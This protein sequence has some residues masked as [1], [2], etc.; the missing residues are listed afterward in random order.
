MALQVLR[1]LSVFPWRPRSGGHRL[2]GGRRGI[3]ILT[4]VFGRRI[5]APH[6]NPK[7]EELWSLS[8][9]QP[10]R[11]KEHVRLQGGDYAHPIA[12]G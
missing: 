4:L 7:A 6:P 5:E 8:V 2:G 3:M 9:M 12:Q 10:V 11:T 1:A